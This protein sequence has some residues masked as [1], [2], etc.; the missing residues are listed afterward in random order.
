MSGPSRCLERCRGLRIS[1]PDS[2][3]EPA[4][5]HLSDV[6]DLSSFAVHRLR[7]LKFHPKMVE[8]SWFGGFRSALKG[9]GINEGLREE[10]MRCLAA[11]GVVTKRAQGTQNLT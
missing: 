1:G 7:G 8:P 9:S 2:N 4:M 5:G 6:R 3:Q 10:V 11:G